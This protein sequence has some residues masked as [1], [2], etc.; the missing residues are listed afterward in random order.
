ML[1]KMNRRQFGELTA[2]LGILGAAPL[3]DVACTGGGSANSVYQPGQTLTL[4]NDLIRAEWTL[5][6]PGFRIASIQD[7]HS[8]Q[9]ITGPQPA[10]TLILG[11]GSVLDSVNMPATGAPQQGALAPNLQ[12][13]RLSERLAGQQITVVFEDTLGRVRVT[14]RG[15]L[16][17][18]SHYVRQQVTLEAIGTPQPI[19]QIRLLEF[20]MPGA[21]VAGDVDGSPITFGEWFLGFEHPLSKSVV[22][23]SSVQCSLARRLA[24]NPGNASSYSSVVGLSAQGQLR[25]DFL[26]YLERERAHPYRTFLLYDSWL[27]LPEDSFDQTEALDAIAAFSNQLYVHRKVAIDSFAFDDGWDNHNSVWDF[28]SGFPNGFAPLKDAAALIQAAPGVWLSPWGGYGSAFQERL[29]AGISQG[30]ET[31]VVGGF[32]LSG[33]RYFQRFEQVCTDMIRLYGVN[34]LKFDGVGGAIATVPGTLYD[35]DYDAALGL[36]NDLRTLMPDLFVNLTI[37]SYPSP[38]WL[39]WVDSTW[40]GGNDHGYAGVGTNR[41]QWITY[42]DAATL[43]HVVQSAPLYPLNSLMLCGLIYANQA[44]LLSTDPYGDF[45]AEVRSFFGTGTQTQE[46]YITPSLLSAQNWDS[47]A[48]AANWSRQNAPTLLDTHWVG[49][50]PGQLQVYGWAAWSSAKGIITLRNP[51]AQAQTFDLDIGKVFEL[52]AG[53]PQQGTAHSPWQK[54]AGTPSIPF[55]AGS[56]LTLDLEPFEVLT[57]EVTF[58]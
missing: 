45:D 17:D 4:A 41:Q 10:F 1:R 57:L 11:D 44:D 8:G 18:G 36:A 37:G 20:D 14:W 25:R 54:D 2:R 56:P 40:R 50:D 34:Y 3:I 26:R 19:Q 35:S 48:E 13:S 51:A 39:L 58:T 53:A 9:V 21:Q 29:A 33:P 15:I 30:Y 32:A 23:G 27:D 28:N 49:G 31:D 5:A 47:L 24:L 7:L 52:P 38:F 46:M 12:A 42:R 22:N 43:Q 6:S 55:Q 16:R